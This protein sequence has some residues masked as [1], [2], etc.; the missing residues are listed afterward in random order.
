MEQ[1]SE[2]SN[3]YIPVMSANIVWVIPKLKGYN[4]SSHPLPKDANRIY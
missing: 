3:L 2:F 4:F 1:F